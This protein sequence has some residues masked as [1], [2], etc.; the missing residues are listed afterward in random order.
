M[1]G[2]SIDPR[3]R[4]A[5]RSAYEMPPAAVGPCVWRSSPTDPEAVPA[6]IT[7]A[8]RRSV[9]LTIFAPDNR[10]GIPKDGVRHISD[11]ELSDNP[12]RSSG[13]WDY[14]PDQVMIQTVQ[15]LVF[16]HETEVINLQRQ[17]TELKTMI[18]A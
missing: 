1:S 7:Q 8:G 16:D 14:T 11:P 10:G 4:A 3:Q 9:L 5:V 18:G 2:E 6:F 12:D 15:K 13:C 17:I